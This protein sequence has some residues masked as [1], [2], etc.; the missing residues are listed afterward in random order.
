MQKPIRQLVYVVLI[1]D[2]AQDTIPGEPQ[3]V[4]GVLV[5]ISSINTHLVP[6]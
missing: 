2:Y 3:D 5:L 6:S 1:V 4:L